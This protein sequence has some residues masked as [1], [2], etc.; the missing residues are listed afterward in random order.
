MLT[1]VVIV[2]D[3]SEAG[4]LAWLNRW[5]E[6]NDSRKQQLKEISLREGG[7]NK[8][9]SATVYAA[10]FN[11]LPLGDFEEAVRRAPWN[12]PESVA[13]YI[14]FE[15]DRTRVVTPGRPESWPLSPEPSVFT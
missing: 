3:D 9:T 6:E 1:D 2:C 14:D 11:F 7:G 13:A 10:C 8:A 15:A 12:F 4:A 5:L